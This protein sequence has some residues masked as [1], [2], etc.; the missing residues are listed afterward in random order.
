MAPD[1]RNRPPGRRGSPP[2]DPRV[3]ARRPPVRPAAVARAPRAPRVAPADPRAAT[4]A[5]ARARAGAGM[6]RDV[7]RRAAA[8][9]PRRA[10]VWRPPAPRVRITVLGT[11]RRLIALVVAIAVIFSVIALRLLDVQ[12][13]NRSHYVQLG[14]DQRVHRITVAPERGGIFDRNGNDLA[15]SVQRQTIWADPHVIKH[16]IEYAAQLAPIVGVPEADLRA[17][18]SQK[19]LEFVYIARQVDPS[20]VA[21]VKALDL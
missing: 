3:T 13:A 9:A 21:R 20:V 15:L 14:V 1:V 6:Q 19:K 2:P 12:A 10:P 17:K 11:R 4:L 18:L 5:R 16:P 8:P 7:P